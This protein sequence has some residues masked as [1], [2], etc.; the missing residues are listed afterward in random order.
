MEELNNMTTELVEGENN[1]VEVASC[2]SGSGVHAAVKVALIATGAVA[3]TVGIVKGAMAL[4]KRRKQKKQ[5][6]VDVATY[7]ETDV[8]DVPVNE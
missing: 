5:A 6:T 4:Y 1:I 8:I 3:A 2:N 7:D